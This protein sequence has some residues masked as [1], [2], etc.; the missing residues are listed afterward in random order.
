MSRFCFSKSEKV[1]DLDIHCDTHTDLIKILTKFLQPL[2]I[3]LFL[4][5]TLIPGDQCYEILLPPRG[6][7]FLLQEKNSQIYESLANFIFSFTLKSY[8]FE[9]K[10]GMKAARG[11]EFLK[12]YLFELKREMKS[13]RDWEDEKLFLQREISKKSRGLLNL[14]SIMYQIFGM[15]AE[16]YKSKSRFFFSP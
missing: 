13:K 14:E 6:S 3:K 8:L 7:Y 10:R 12:N 16:V 5:I 4:Y 1:L 9:V 15:F 2:G 11:R